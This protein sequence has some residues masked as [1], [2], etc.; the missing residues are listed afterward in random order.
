MED[1]EID[2]QRL[3]FHRIKGDILFGMPF[4][5]HEQTSNYAFNPIAEQ[6]LRP[7]QTIMPQR[8]NAALGFKRQF[9][10]TQRLRA[11]I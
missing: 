1:E 6:A 5:V 7:N 2:E 9:T 11:P 8:V 4:S 10:G 3:G